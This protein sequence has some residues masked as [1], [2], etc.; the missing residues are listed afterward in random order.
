MSVIAKR[1]S[2]RAREHEATVRLIRGLVELDA[3]GDHL[4]HG[5]S[6][7]WDFLVR[8]LHYSNAAASRRYKAMKCAKKFPEVL[9]MLR[10]HETNLSALAIAEATLDRAEDARELLGEIR[11]KSQRQVETIVA[12]R[13]PKARRR[14]RVKRVAVKKTAEPDLFTS[15]AEVEV[16]DCVH[17]SFDVGEATYEDLQK[18]KAILSRKMPQG[19]TLDALLEELLACYLDH[20]APKPPREPKRSTGRHIPAATRDEVFRRDEGRCTYVGP[21]GVR[22]GTDHDLEVDHIQPYALGGASELGNLRL[23]CARHNRH[24]ARRTF[25]EAPEVQSS[26]RHPDSG[27]LVSATGPALQPT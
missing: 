5:Y 18:A 26:Q 2:L 13:N 21:T 27:V 8:H 24:R 6:G 17:L 10:K 12:R 1:E 22:C 15:A 20:H 11:G 4:T 23:L 25:G 3:R 19:V 16:E 14:E 9:S 7:V